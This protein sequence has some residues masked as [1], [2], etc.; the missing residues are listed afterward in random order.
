MDLAKNSRWQVVLP[1]PTGTPKATGAVYEHCG[2]HHITFQCC[3]EHELARRFP[4]SIHPLLNTMV[5]TQHRFC[6]LIGGSAS[7]PIQAV[8]LFRH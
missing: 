5:M 7:G 1:S 2:P 4:Y 8:E 6:L 3:L